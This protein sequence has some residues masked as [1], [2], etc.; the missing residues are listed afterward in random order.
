M[1]VKRKATNVVIYVFAVSYTHLIQ[2]Y[3]V[4]VLADEVAVDI[5]LL[6]VLGILSPEHLGHH[7]LFRQLNGGVAVDDRG[8]QAAALLDGFSVLC[9]VIRLSLIP[10]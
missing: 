9:A 3:G 7:I 5:N 8:F 2:I 10:I 1:K 6:D 4:T